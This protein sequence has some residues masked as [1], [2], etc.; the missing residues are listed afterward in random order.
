MPKSKFDIDST[1]GVEGR[2]VQMLEDIQTQLY[3]ERK[4]SG[5]VQRDMAHKIG[6]MLTDFNDVTEDL[7]QSEI[8]RGLL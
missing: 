1:Y 8:Y 6:L 5:D 3:S 4:M 2:R 7:E